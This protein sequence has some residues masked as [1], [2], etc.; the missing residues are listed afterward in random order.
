MKNKNKRVALFDPYLNTLGGGEKY[1]LSILEVFAEQGY[2]INIFWDK[3]LTKEIK[4]RFVLHY[5]NIMKFLP[6]I[7]KNNSSPLKTLQTLKTYDYFFYVTDGS[8]FFSGAK[9]N[10]I[11]AM[12]PD[13]KLYSQSLINKLK[14]I[15][16]QFI[17]HSN[18]TQKWLNK[19]GI[20]STVIMPYLD[21]KLI[22]Q[23]I[24]SVKKE[25]VIL[26]VGRFFSHLH[27]KK[28]DLMIKTFKDLK[29]KCKEFADYKLVLAGGLMKEDKKYFNSL[30]KL[31]GNDPTIIFKPNIKLHELYKLYKL[32]NYF[33]H[34]TGYGVDEEKNPELVEHFG[35]TPLEAMASDCLTFC[36]SAGGPKELIKDGKNG[37]LFSDT[38][39]LIDKMTKIDT[40]KSLKEKVIN[41]GKLFT[42]NNFSYEVFKEKVLSL[43]K[44]RPK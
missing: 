9:K 6:N 3:N 26:S 1:I 30:K 29:N 22:N 35:I 25:K 14:L 11:Y 42:K 36:Y 15:N 43:I 10:F 27:S 7:F 33:W 23:N 17:T 32:S 13:K 19:F 18:F 4:N 37:F 12:I 5:I 8:Y 20:K 38:N 34:F 44:V 24:D 39:E 21:D 2:E 16:Y 31:S 28:Q 40:N 41:N